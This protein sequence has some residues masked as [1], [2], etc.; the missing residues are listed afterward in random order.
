ML[1]TMSLTTF[2][3]RLS[4]YLFDPTYAVWGTAVLDTCIRQALQEFNAANPCLT[5]GTLTAAGSTRELALSSLTGL[6]DVLRVWFPYTAATPE[7]PPTWAKFQTYD[8]A[9]TLSL[10]LEVQTAPVAGQVARV[11]YLKNHTL[12]ALD[13]AGGTTFK[14]RDEGTLM[15]GAAGHALMARAIKLSEDTT[16]NAQAV[17]NYAEMARDYLLQ[18]RT[19]LGQPP[20][21]NPAA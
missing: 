9:G 3:V 18:F 20:L 4:N 6:A 10:Y 12:S 2:E 16:Q 11:Y 14:L 15:L 7:Q 8:N 13:G 19:L 5:V 17:P 1:S 21:P